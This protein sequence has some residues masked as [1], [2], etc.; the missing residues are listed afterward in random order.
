MTMMNDPLTDALVAPRLNW[1]RVFASDGVGQRE[2]YEAWRDANVAS[3]STRYET[4]PHEPFAVRMDW[5]DLGTFGIGQARITSND[6]IRTP[7]KI[8]GDQCDDVVINIR[9]AGAAKGDF[10]GRDLAAPSGSIVIAD[11]AR[12][13]GH[14]SEASISTGLALPRALAQQLMPQ[15]DSLHGHVIAPD[16]AALLVSHVDAMRTQAAHLPASSGPML[17]QTILDLFAMSLA[18]S[19]GDKPVDQAQHERALAVQLRDVIERQLGS[20]SLN[21]ARLSR[22]L[23]VSRSTLYRLLQDEGGVQAYI[24]ARRLSR[25]ADTLRNPSERP[26]ISAL[27]ERWGFCDAAYLGRAFREAYGITPGEYRAL[28]GAGAR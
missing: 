25:I 28:H 21:T 4:V 18:A 7:A 5:L 24:R 9:H 11:L 17:A 16:H 19:M 26:T 6:W 13:Q 20:P 22:T 12:P 3:L 1:N 2:Q 14:W 10:N 8:A 23:G 15:L 27:A